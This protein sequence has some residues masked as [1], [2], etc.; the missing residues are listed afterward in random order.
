[1]ASCSSGPPLDASLRI[2]LSFHPDR[3]VAGLPI[4]ESLARD[5][6]YRSQFETGSSNGG[7]TAHPGGDRWRWESRIFGGAYDDTEASER[8]KYGALNYRRRRAG[9]SPRFGS[10]YLRLTGEVLTRSTFCFPDSVLEPVQFGVAAKMSLTEVAGAALDL[11]LLD[12]YIE[13]QVHGPVRLDRDVEA[14]VL[15]PCFRGTEVETRACSLSCPVEWHDGFRLSTQEL[16]RHPDYRAQD[17]VDLG[18]RIAHDGYLDARLIGQAADT[19]SYD[20]QALKRVWHYVAR[21]GVS[22]ITP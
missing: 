20:E 8:P 6:I 15:D 18:V 5:G 2:T 19:G 1:M 11:D 14:L 22:A 4:L 13:A 9:A 7:L 10:A 16:R 3:W 17:F 12:D 21:F